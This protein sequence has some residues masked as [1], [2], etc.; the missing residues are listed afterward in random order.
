GPYFD[1]NTG[2]NTIDITGKTQGGNHVIQ[3]GGGFNI[4]NKAQVN[5][6]GSDQ[7][8]LN[9]AH[10]TSKST[11]EGVLNAKGNNVFLI[12]P[13]GV[14][15][16][17]TGTINANRFV[18]STSSLKPEDFDKFKAQGASFSPVFKPN[19]GNV[20]NMGTI[21][22][23][24]I[25]LQGNKVMLSADTSW[26]D[27]NNKIKLNQITA[28]NNIDLK[29]NEVY[30]DI[31][32]IN[33]NNL[34]TEAKNKG[35]AYLSATGYYY[36]PKRKYNDSIFTNKGVMDKTYNQY[37]SIG[38]DLDWWHFAK[39]WDEKAD[40]R[41]NVAGNTFKLTN[42]I[43]F[44]ANCKN[45]VCAGQ[46]YANYW[47]DLNG[48]GEKDANEFTNMIVG[49][50]N[51]FTNTFDGQGFTLKNINMDTTILDN[52]PI[53]VGLFGRADGANFKNINVDYMGG[54]LK[55]SN[56]VHSGGFVAYSRDSSFSNISLN[57]I[58]HINHE[59]NAHTMIGGFVGIVYDSS[60]SN[61]S[62]NNIGNINNI[63]I[64][65]VSI[66]GFVGAGQSSSFSNISLSN[67][68]SIKNI[69]GDEVAIGGFVGAGSSYSFS[70]ISLSN[71]GSIE[72]INGDE[73]AIG[74]FVGAGHSSSFS[75]I[76]LSNIGDISGI[77]DFVS[78]GGFA[79][80]NNGDVKYSKIYI[81]DI[82]NI[83]SEGAYD[84]G[85]YA[86]G[87]IGFNEYG[88]FSD[89][90]VKNIGNISSIS[91]GL[92]YSGGFVGGFD[93]GEFKRI[94]LENITNINSISKSTFSYAG[95]FAG[96]SIN[97]PYAS[98][99]FTN[100]YLKD[101][102]N[103][104]SHGEMSISGGFAGEIVNTVEDN[105]IVFDRISIDNINNIEAKGG[106]YAVSGGFL[107]ELASFS[108]IKDIKLSNIDKIKVESLGTGSAS[109]GG[110]AGRISR[111]SKFENIVLNNFG[112]IIGK[113]FVGGFVGEIS[114]SSSSNPNEFNNISLNNFGNIIGKDS[115]G[116]FVGFDTRAKMSNI[117]LN[118]IDYIQGTYA[119]GFTGKGLGN[120]GNIAL[121]NIKYIQGTY[122]GGFA[123]FG[124]GGK[125]IFIYFDKG[126]IIEGLE[127][128]GKFFGHLDEYF[129][130]NT[131]NTYI[132]YYK[133]DLTNATSDQ[134]YWDKE[135]RLR[136]YDDNSQ[137]Y[138][139]FKTAA[140]AALNGLKEIDCG[141]SKKCLVFTKDFEVEKPSNPNYPSNVIVSKPSQNTDYIP[142]T[143]DIINETATLDENDLYKDIIINEIISD[144]K[145]KYYT[146]DIADLKAILEAY[147]NLD[148][149]S[150]EAR[151]KFIMDYF[152][153]KNNKDNPSIEIAQKEIFQSL[154]F[155]LAYQD[156]GL[157]KASDDKFADNEAIQAKDNILAEVSN[158][159]ENKTIAS[160]LENLSN[161]NDKINS[162]NND[163]KE[164]NYYKQLNDLASA[165]NKYV[166]LINKGLVSKDDQ[167]FKDISNELFD[168]IAKVGD[169]TEAIERLIKDFE[170]L[171]I[172]VSD[173][174]SGRFVV[175]GELS[176]IKIPYPILASIKDD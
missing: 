89:I 147:K 106:Y 131:E 121:N 123:G 13:N 10:G 124:T 24:N 79:G 12:N 109:T 122:A 26:D 72:N 7:N 29:G 88:E 18:A 113:D 80:R 144:L 66:G 20:V 93:S 133:D 40:F 162:A 60:F 44:G 99:Y 140:L 25:T 169:E 114:S 87:F 165:Y 61:I 62:L 22:A 119:G 64:D 73:V 135:I 104:S 51:S 19:G 146:I 55:L 37:I 173:E 168:L 112:N 98:F 71:I 117:S 47:V 145:N 108:T 65:G 3:W 158:A 116:G 160:N 53:Y 95:G 16:T 35:I 176:A 91:N 45:G 33:S 143:E 81:S 9:I 31:S 102:L 4:G 127:S 155:L 74:G 164:E 57:N 86:G 149:N 110:F 156:N 157:D 153:D 163:F 166:E 2:K 103:I 92:A 43:D 41:N 107:G 50:N 125:N 83:S 67:I 5:F 17:K 27:K 142:S 148:K 101:I 6:K 23:K 82:K 150:A 70:N 97:N 132:Y 152:F 171:K 90:T 58:N 138:I 96:G 111:S 154:D 34:T 8:Y 49:Y 48:D 134:K 137:G 76:S 175:K 42:N 32:T 78:V 100:I 52:K 126:V 130:P 11:I 170:D 30:V 151:T 172:S 36:N 128:S 118:N 15:I 94:S 120:Y 38:S 167:A 54:G 161:L 1:K 141:V 28:D 105:S 56:A 174:S 77:G 75:N 59:N 139:D 69:N 159:L 136:P 63:G 129:I 14:I 39:G 115:V 46:N 85:I 84:N 21:N 68:G